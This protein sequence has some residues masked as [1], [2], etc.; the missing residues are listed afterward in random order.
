MSER[1][2]SARP[3]I[4]SLG[5]ETI[6]QSRDRPK[7]R[8]FEP[9]M[10]EKSVPDD[11]EA[12]LGR[13][14]VE[15]SDTL[16]RDYDVADILHTLASRC[17]EIFPVAEAGILLK[18]PDNHLHTVAL[19]TESAHTMDLHQL[20]K[21]EGPC[22][23][24][25]ET[26]ER[27]SIPDLREESE[28]W[29]EYV[30]RALELELMSVDAL[31]LRLREQSVGA[32]NLFR[33]ELGGSSSED[34]SIMQA[35]ADV[36]TIG[37]LQARAVQN[38]EDLAGHLQIALDSRVAIEQAKGIVAENLNV[39]LSDAFDLLRQYSQ[40]NN[41]KLTNLCQQVVDG[42]LRPRDLEPT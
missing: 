30:E 6:L 31:P 11:R 3:L 16:V 20:Q 36:A 14:F 17:V 39:G 41:E 42:S 26:G 32:L 2:W 38:A 24:A 7:E 13:A 29:P 33:T 21:E 12:R 9:T 19:S 27:L 4:C 23:V 25:M 10:S 8:E 18:S 15:L 5:P 1:R 40:N 35:M 34:L 37:L 28:R 22:W